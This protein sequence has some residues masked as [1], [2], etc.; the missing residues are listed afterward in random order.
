MTAFD[1]FHGFFEIGHGEAAARLAAGEAPACAVWG[2]MIGES[3][4]S[5]RD[6]I[7]PGPHGAGDYAG[8]SG[9]HLDCAF[10][11]E[12]DLFAEVFFALGEVVM[13]IDAFQL[14]FGLVA[15]LTEEFV[16]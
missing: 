10:A 5:S 16:G 9:L 6:D 2:R 13:A 14:D 12:P 3:I 15:V 7:A 11:G 4:F 8:L 1:A